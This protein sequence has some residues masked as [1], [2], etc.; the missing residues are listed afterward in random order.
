MQLHVRLLPRY[1]RPHFVVEAQPR[2]DCL[3]KRLQAVLVALLPD[4]RDIRKNIQACKCMAAVLSHHRLKV[5]RA[6]A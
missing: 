6:H 3:E 4:I 5:R 2:F 1:E